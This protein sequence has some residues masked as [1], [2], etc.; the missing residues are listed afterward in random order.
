M[1]GH[2]YRNHSLVQAFVALQIIGGSAFVLVVLS[3]FVAQRRGGSRHP[4]FF[5]FCFSWIIFCISYALLSFAGQQVAV[6]G[7]DHGLCVVQA[8]LVYAAPPLAGSATV[9]LVTHLMLNV[10]SALS[11]SPM[12]RRSSMMSVILVLVPWITWVAVLVGVLLFGVHHPDLVGLSPNGTFCALVKTSLPKLTSVWAT[13]ASTVLFSQEVIVAVL[14]YRNRDIIS[15]FGQSIAMAIRIGVFTIMGIAA[16]AVALVFTVTEKRGVQFD[17]LLASIPLSAAVIF[18]SQWD[19]LRVWMFWKPYDA[20][21]EPAQRSEHSVVLSTVDS[22]Q[23]DL[24]A[25]RHL[26]STDREPV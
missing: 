7:P 18:G 16:I 13:I 25:P 1:D 22:S 26:P 23:T 20:D 24:S 15:G 19:L 17:V 10:L 2:H 3:A 8:A 11:E 12:K 14:L 5:S 6:P 9:S 21:S 4:T